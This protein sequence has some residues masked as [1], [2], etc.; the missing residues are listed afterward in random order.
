M[1][2]GQ[3][4]A[5]FSRA[6]P[7]THRVKPVYER[8][9]MAIV[10][11]VQRWR[12][13]LLG[14]HFVVRTDQK[15][16]KFLLEQRVVDGDYQRWIAKLMGYDFSIEY[17]KGLENR[18]ADALSRMPEKCEL[19]MLSVVAGI[20]TAVFTQQVKEDDKLMEIYKSVT[21]GKGAPPGYSVVGDVLL[22]Q[23]RL[24]L[25]PTS[26]TIPLLLL[27]FHSGAIGGHFG[28]LK[29]YQ[30]LAKEVYWQGM[31]ARVRSFVAECS[32]CVQAK[33]LSLS[34]AGLLQPLPIPAQVWEDISMDFVEGLPRSEGYDTIL[35]VVD[36]LSK[37]SH[38][39]P[40]RHPFSSLSVSKVFIKE[41]V[42]L[43]GIPK[44][45]ISDRDK[46]FTSLLWEEMFKATGTKLCRSTTYHP[47]TDGQTEVVNRCLE[48]YLRCFVMHHPKAWYQWLSWAEYSFNTSFHSSTGMTPFEIIYGRPPPTLLGYDH[49][50]SPVASVDSLM[51]DRDRILTTLKASLLRAQQS[52][53]DRAN[54]KRRDVQ[55]N[56]DDLVYIKLR[57]YRQ[58]SLAKFQHP[59]L[60]PRFIGPYRV[61]ARVGPVAYRLELPPAVKIHPV[62]HVSVLRKAGDSSV[63]VM[64]TPSLVG[65]DLCMVVRPKAVLG[66]QEN[67]H[68]AGSR[69]VL[70]QW[71]G[72][73]PED[74]TWESA[75]DLE[76]QFPDF[77]LE[78]KVALWGGSIDTI[79]ASLKVYSR[80]SKK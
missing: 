73:A 28:V 12:A 1:Q 44:S 51:K 18:A 45:I 55:F 32:I 66:V 31:K 10:F 13:Y 25:P 36:R 43:H 16:L 49:G 80:R 24:V 27:E 67:L 34:P 63:I 23:G 39:I 2:Q 41:I 78:D 29:T 30:R 52:M 59:K 42:R 56:I 3:P 19:G 20:N 33:H 38:F 72:S 58:S 9:L 50:V 17:K 53:A 60:A 35:V 69:Q 46:V 8:E 65:D 75:A 61:L 48:S 4:I 14:H 6:L 37:Y 70:V 54:A 64:S 47:Q 22:Y 7:I 11:A 62:F 15:S 26:P 68:A 77:H 5:Y 40:L 57:P 21:A 71:E 74:A 79:P 76:L